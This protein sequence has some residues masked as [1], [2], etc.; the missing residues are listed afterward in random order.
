[1]CLNPDDVI[2]GR[3]QIIRQLGSGGFGVTYLARDNH[4]PDNADP[5]VLKQIPL[6]Q[7]EENGEFRDTNYLSRL[8]LE[9][10]TLWILN[11]SC[12]PRFFARFTEG[13]YFYIVQ[14]YI[15]GHDL[16]QEIVAGEPIEE[17][18]AVAMLRELLRLLQ[19][20][21]ARN[22]I[23]RDIKPANI[24]RRNGDNSLVLID[25]G[26]VK[27]KATRHTSASGTN[28]TQ[29]IYT[30]GY[31]PAEQLA[32][33]PQLNSDIHALGIMI[34][35]GV[36]GFSI[37]AINSSERAPRRDTNNGCKY[38]WQSYAPQISSGLKEIISKMIE[39]HFSD[40]YQSAAE[41]LDAL[42]NLDAN[43]VDPSPVNSDPVSQ[44]LGT[45]NLGTTIDTSGDRSTESGSG[46]GSNFSRA[47]ATSLVLAF[48][49]I[50]AY[51]QRINI[52][53]MI[54][55][56]CTSERG[57]YLSCGEEIL[58]TASKSNVRKRAADAMRA[59][60]YELALEYYQSSWQKDARDAETLIYMNNALLE[61]SKA[62]YYT[63]AVAVPLSYKPGIKAKNYELGQDLLRGVAEA[64]TE[65][66][67]S[68]AGLDQAAQYNLPGKDF[69]KPRL[70]SP[71]KSKGL[72]IVIIDDRNSEIES[73]KMAPTIAA[74]PKILGL[75]GHYASN[76]TLGAI[77]TY[78]K[79]KLPQVSPTTSTSELSEHPRTSFFRVVYT[80][81][82]DAQAISSTLKNLA[83]KNKKVAIFYNPGS[84]YS[85][86]LR[87]KLK[88][89]IG[90]QIVKEFNIAED[91]NFS[92]SLA[93]QEAKNRGTNIFILLPD[94][95]ETNALAKAI[96]II[97]A[98]N[99]NTVILGG[100][101]LAN[102]KIEQIKTDRPIQL[103]ASTYWH[104]LVD[105]EGEFTQ[106]SQKLWGTEINGKTATAYDATL[107]LIEAIKL[108]NN[109]TRK[110]VLNQLS[111]P[112]F[113][114]DGA[115]GQ[116]IE[117]NRPENGDR[118]NF[119]PTLVRLVNCGNS[120]FFVPLSID[121]LEASNLACQPEK[122]T[123]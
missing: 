1:M 33:I 102:S 34:M 123:P 11:H 48:I 70:I 35:Q 49:A 113:S 10:N 51:C 122:S 61:A 58:Y 75:I 5:L 55:P 24:I 16:S 117:F 100:N 60:D 115:T 91:Q 4:Q 80:T 93:L 73:K 52:L 87:F 72:K 99:G 29:A 98:D 84:D 57:D 27:E 6:T 62:D 30:S 40:R 32:G 88:E 26:A 37:Q 86:N 42:D 114:F 90:N 18:Q 85:N 17:A 65:I 81:R 38:D 109:P 76:V 95:Q 78:E 7:L 45:T 111:T 67:L 56:A 105:P 50:A 104:P 63:L 97:E 12:I 36:T 15:A 119:T 23:H 39:F 110:N 46:F 64:Q 89:T 53:S 9:A 96:E 41:V 69:L 71:Q 82:E 107:A 43:T 28:L 121:N 14:E 8:E 68:L 21:H 44:N 3:Y 66:N 101:P 83:I 92:T 120:N 116:D 118:L 94:G 22:I 19:F 103:I 77:D 47:I 2:S 106:D 31:A 74:K 79:E 20:I 59:G 108:Q 54:H 13:E 25:F 112:G